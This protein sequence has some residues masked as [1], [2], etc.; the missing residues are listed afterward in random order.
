MHTLNLGILAHV[1]AGKTSLTERLLHTAGVIDEIGSVDDGN[2][3]TDSLALERERGI[4]IKSAV[5]SFPID[6][7]TV[8]LIDTPGHPDFIAEVERVL[9]VLDGAM[10]VISA[11]EGVQAQTRVLMRTLRRL[12][13]PTLIFVNKVD[14]G[15]AQEES[16]LRSIS[17]KLTPAVIAMGSVDGRGCRDA[18]CT[19]Y[20]GAD[21]G[22]TDR[23]AELLT[24]QDDALLA[25][26]VEN[27]A[28]LPY[29]RLREE[30]AV[31]TGQ[32]LVH[33]VFFGSAITGVGVDALISGVRE[34]LPASAGD[35]DGPVS[36]T[37]FKVERGPGGEKIA[38]VRMFSGTVRIRDR[39]PFGRSGAHAGGGGD[40]RGGGGRGEGKVTAIS[41]FD[42]GSAL[43]GA[44]V[45]AGRI[46]RLRGLGGIRV[47]DMVGEPD[48]TGRRNWFAPPTLESVVA[49]SAPVNRGALHFA[50][51]QLAEQDPLI[52][53]RQDGIRKEVSVSLYGEVQKE[54]IQATLADE[55]GID[56]TFRETTTIC[57]ERPNGSGAAYEIIGQDPNPFLATV[58]LRVDPAPIGS[59]IEYRLE[60]ELGSM[61]YS[62]MRA[63]EETVGETLR[64]GI[65]GWQVTD[66][67]VTMT[68]SGYWPRQSH[69]HG[70]F[71]KSMS[72][73]AGDFRNLTPLVL[74]SAL[75][76]AGT[77]VHEPMH[78]FRLELPTGL[79]GPVLP[80]LAPLGAVPG[81]PAPNG[82]V[83]VLEGEIPAARVHGLQQQLP[84]L[85]RG[86]GVLESEFDSY[87][88]VRGAPPARPRT[89]RDPLNRKEYLLHTVRRVAGQ[90]DFR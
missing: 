41:V 67:V 15:G 88:A 59:G 27:A 54:V 13:I 19:P 48:T 74:M 58:G 62:L 69:S 35:A 14:R 71:D 55:F 46:A 80:V 77:T 40:G 29:R 64:Q 84:A 73:T 37:V 2:T 86:E 20:T 43:R 68:H 11:V 16:L 24:D 51:A 49:P 25:A 21:P 85:T 70:V 83:C 36:G 75:K 33:P 81:T 22:F 26:Y 53:L 56:V 45:G 4:T 1:D 90:G 76:Q 12:R 57:L 61:P 47:G 10:L 30:L 9:N 82:A 65:H 78:R 7:I 66:C 87:R 28:P 72:S 31:Q 6:D 50:L 34:L 17:E 52:N 8:N 3:Q 63:V 38:Y 60:V 79:L 18:R 89:D 32:A 39:L 44:A 42:R 5:V 23:L